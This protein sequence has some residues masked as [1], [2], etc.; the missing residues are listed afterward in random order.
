MHAQINDLEREK[1]ERGRRERKE[2]STV[3]NYN[4]REFPSFWVEKKKKH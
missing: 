4:G 2:R 1:S 3:G